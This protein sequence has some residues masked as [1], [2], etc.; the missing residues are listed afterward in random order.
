[1]TILPPKH[2]LVIAAHPDDIEFGAA[3]TIA[4]W[5]AAGAR[6]TFCMVTNGGAGSNK[7]GA[8]LPALIQQR[9][10]EQCAAAEILGVK[11][12]RFMGYQD[13][14][15]QP[16]LELRRDLTRIIRELKPDRVMIQDPTMFFAGN[17]YINHPDHRAAGEAA[18]Y[19]VFPSAGTRPIFP[20][21]LEEGLEPFDPS[22]LWLMFATVSETVIDITPHIDQKIQ[23]LLC[24]KSQLGEEVVEMVKSWDRESGKAQGYTYAETFHVMTLKPDEE[25][26]KQ[27]TGVSLKPVGDEPNA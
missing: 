14:I 9:Q 7:P 10:E 17:Y 23:A 27:G 1:M 20:E 21:L 24:H 22:Q 16:T 11:D 25:E 4:A 26:Q 2:L 8:D 15:L 18:A 19:A 13:G 5:T 3:G 12:V 6:V